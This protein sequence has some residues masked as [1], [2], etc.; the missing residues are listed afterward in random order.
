MYIM[1]INGNIGRESH[2]PSVFLFKDAK[3]VYAAEE[4]RFTRDKFSIGKLPLNAIKE[5]LDYEKIKIQDIDYLA[6]PQETWGDIFAER[7]TYFFK[8]NFGYVPLIKYF[9]HHLCHA[10]STYFNSGF[11]EDSLV[12]TFDGSGDGIA[13]GIY[14]GRQGQLKLLKSFNFPDSFGLY[15]SLITQYLG[16]K[17]NSDEYKI[18][19]LASYGEP[20]YDLSDILSPTDDGYKLNQKYINPL[21]F[22]LKYPFYM[23]KQEPFFNIDEFS[24]LGRPRLKHERITQFHMDFAA[25]AQH[26]LEEV[27]KN[28]IVKYLDKYNINYVCLGGGTAL[29]CVL[30]GQLIKMPQIKEIYIPPV[31]NDSGTA[32]GAAILMAM[33]MGIETEPITNAYWGTK[34]DSK[35]V[36]AILENNNIKFTDYGEKIYEVTA[37]KLAEGKIIGWFQDR[38]EIGPRALGNRSILADPRKK[39]IKDVINSK[40]KNRCEFQPFAPSVLEEECDKFFN[41]YNNKS[42]YMNITFDA[43]EDRKSEIQGVVHVDGTSRVQTVNKESNEKYYDLLEAFNR[44]TGIPV[45]LNTSLNMR[46][47]P[48]ARTPENALGIL[49]STGLNALVIGS[50]Y[51]EK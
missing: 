37:S 45:L 12:V 39:E 11:K 38:M 21:M 13:T 31:A 14:L 28:L 8:Y 29:N 7:L 2:D 17:K 15:Y 44:V 35:Q 22:K 43:K 27:F 16:F 6:F 33:D 18:M 24:K 1:G 25:S 9:N 32:L 50:I 19:S 40:I 48:I 51:I 3:L 26:Q 46:N 42:P 49:Y 47:E 20:K 41:N 34:Y 23:T 10:A 5:C 4:E 30:N 36:R